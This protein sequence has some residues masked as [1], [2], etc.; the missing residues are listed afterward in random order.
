MF[1]DK[2]RTYI[3]I[4]EDNQDPKKLG[5]CRV[6]VI[7][8][9]DDIPADDIPWASPWKDLNGNG[10]NV[11][12]KGKVLTVIFDSGNIYK[13]E[14]L[15]AEHYNIN[16]E[17]KLQTLSGTNYTSM[18]ALIFDHKTQI[19]VNDDE[20]LKLDHKFNM[21]NITKEGIDLNL[22]DNFANV[23]IGT[24]TANQ[25]AILGN[26][27][28]NWFDEFVSNLLGERSGPYLGNLGAPVVCNPE[29]IEC[30]QKYRALKEP[31]FL[32]HHVNIVDNSYV[33][34]L[35]RVNDSQVGD[36]YKS[37]TGQSGSPSGYSSPSE[38]VD[39]KPRDGSSG[40]TPAGQLST[41]VSDPNVDASDQ[42]ND[43]AP[44]P[45]P[46]VNVLIETIQK[47]RARCGGQGYEILSRP[48]EMNI[49]G[50]RFS[51]PGQKYT[52]AYSDD[53]YLFYKDDN[54]FWQMHKYKISTM[55]GV[56]PAE[57]YQ[58]TK[59][60][61]DGTSYTV[62]K[63]RRKQ[64]GQ[65]V[66]TTSIMKGRGGVG[67][68][69]EGFYKN[70]YSIGSF[71]DA[72]AM[73]TGGR[74]QKW[75]RDSTDSYIIKYEKEGEGDSG[76][77]IHKGFANSGSV[78]NWSEGCQVFKDKASYDQFF[79]KCK[80]H[81]NKYGNKFNYTLLLSTDFEGVTGNNVATGGPSNQGGGGGGAPATNVQ[82]PTPNPEEQKSLDEY[83]QIVRLI[84]NIYRLGDNTYTTNNEPL[85]QDTKGTFNDD[86]QMAVD[87][88]YELLGLKSS[89]Q[90][91]AGKLS[92]N[93]LIPAH[94]TSFLQELEQ[95][96]KYTLD[97]TNTYNFKVPKITNGLTEQPIPI[98]SDF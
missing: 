23:N 51:Y 81:Q 72:T 44:T 94:K 53:M 20:G 26:H 36:K 55:P 88:L 59:K 85:F 83:K 29:F 61:K 34:K 54:N 33:T 79:E 45:N 58:K 43:P 30:L 66:K 2:S 3:G 13:P 42:N 84:Q 69:K 27:F 87:R 97:K 71:N 68:L 8:I 75:Y 14:Y 65:N 6:R 77:Y 9:F 92:L 38:P 28:L 91:W 35:D 70:I 89:N 60:R 64:D 63:L 41:T 22:K 31:K 11:P 32:S 17:K 19:Y 24:S 73:V 78:N 1:V 74:K 82:K 67:I 40:D 52:N 57:V 37:S 80:I 16:L 7:D 5:R 12:E 98:S 48:Y 50:V 93:K 25:Q 90:S 46:D 86:V 39:Y 56:Y 18:K 76:M 21:I 10:F 4:V 15:Y 49:V 62:D 47:V 95:L 96:K